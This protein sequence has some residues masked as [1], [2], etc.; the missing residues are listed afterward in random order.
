MGWDA[1]GDRVLPRR[2][3][4]RHKGLTAQHHGQG[5]RPEMRQFRE[6]GIGL[7]HF[8]ERGLIEHVDDERI[9]ERAALDREDLG[10]RRGIG[11]IGREAI[12]RLGRESHADALTQELGRAS[13]VGGSGGQ[14]T[15][16]GRRQGRRNFTGRGGGSPVRFTSGRRRGQPPRLATKRPPEKAA[17]RS[18]RE[19]DYFIVI[20]LRARLTALAI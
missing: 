10:E 13:E 11:R 19:D 18:R 7:G 5:A 2:D 8:G 20:I 4:I 6:A 14:E 3:E 17:R 12:D 15:G 1:D 9:Q 16:G